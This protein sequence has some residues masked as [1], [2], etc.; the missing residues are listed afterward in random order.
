MTILNCASLNYQGATISILLDFFQISEYDDDSFD[1][2]ESE[3]AD[4]LQKFA[5]NQVE[6]RKKFYLFNKIL[7][8]M[9]I[10]H[11]LKKM[12]KK[13][14]MKS[15]N[16]FMHYL[17]KEKLIQQILVNFAP[18]LLMKLLEI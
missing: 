7:K 16:K 1:F 13:K 3:N 6:E 14:K 15:T 12:H 10:S 18:F 5:K 4:S 9:K 17:I 2:I 8:Y 11:L